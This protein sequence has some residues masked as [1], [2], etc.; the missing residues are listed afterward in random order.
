MDGSILRL[1]R[2]I[3]ARVGFDSILRDVFV[4]E[5]L[6]RPGLL[7]VHVGRTGPA[8]TGRRL[9]ATLWSDVDSMVAAVGEDL[10]TSPFHPEHLSSTTDHDLGWWPLTFA[11][12]CTDHD[13]VAILRLVHGRVRAGDQATY[14][15]EAQAGTAADL[16]AGG[17]PCGL[18]LAT[19]AD[20]GFYTLSLWPSWDALLSATGGDDQRPIAT[21]HAERLVAW[22]VE[23]FEALPGLRAMAVRG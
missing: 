19:D 13:E 16:A 2:F 10:S 5:L 3:P 14:V 4:P 20:D 15:A 17:G 6:E 1:F 12:P 9:V 8:E 11:Y 18:Y 22:E 23:H 7:D 21:R